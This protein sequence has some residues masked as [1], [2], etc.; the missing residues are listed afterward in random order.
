[1]RR[2][3]AASLVVA[4]V[5]AC[6]SERRP[7]SSTGVPSANSAPT[8]GPAVFRSFTDAN[9]GCAQLRYTPFEA[10]FGQADLAPRVRGDGGDLGCDLDLVEGRYTGATIYT[11]VR[12]FADVEEAYADYRGHKQDGDRKAGEVV[13]VTRLR[14]RGHR[15]VNGPQVAARPGQLQF[16]AQRG[17][18][19]VTVRVDVLVE[20]DLD[21]EARWSEV[22]DAV[23]DYVN[24][25][26][27]DLPK[28]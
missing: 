1:M 18:V 11:E 26:F 2:V 28:I 22:H 19:G 8:D 5:M 10:L 6:S 15:F 23:T 16:R 9:E 4:S 27:D 17:N 25:T 24:T 21:S 3:V 13:D 14:D 12:F 7:G 20:T